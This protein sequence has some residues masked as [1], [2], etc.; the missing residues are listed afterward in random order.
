MSGD[1]PLKLK[2]FSLSI[3]SRGEWVNWIK[4]RL[5]RGGREVH[6]ETRGSNPL[7]SIVGCSYIRSGATVASHAGL[8]NPVLERELWCVAEGPS[9]DIGLGPIFLSAEDDGN[10]E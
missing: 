2:S 4:C 3:T 10:V 6:L 5:G 8:S 9:V 1:H 7:E